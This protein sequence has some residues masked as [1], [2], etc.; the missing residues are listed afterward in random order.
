M[1]CAK[2]FIDVRSLFCNT[3]PI[4]K[5]ASGGDLLVPSVV[6]L[7]CLR[8]RHPL[9]LRASSQVSRKQEIGFQVLGARV[10]GAGCRV[11]GAGSRLQSGCRAPGA[12]CRAPGAGCRAPGAG[13]RAP[14]A[15][16]R[17]PG[18]GCRVPGSGLRAPGA[19]PRVS[20]AGCQRWATV[21]IAA[22]Q[23]LGHCS[24][25]MLSGRVSVLALAWWVGGKRLT[26]K[27]R[28]A[29]LTACLP[30]TLSGRP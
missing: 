26:V 3:K 6:M 19:G 30:P 8:E 28:L 12:G 1:R 29:S 21:W 17:V 23:G 2:V 22:S 27:G 9:I 18:A 5:Q 7:W 4:R 13:C 25:V 20:G 24:Y 15:G 14:G 11:P 10:P 16:C